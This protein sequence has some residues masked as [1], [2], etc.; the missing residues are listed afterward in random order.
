ML[1]YVIAALLIMHGLAHL[2]G[3]LG[4]LTSGEQAFEDLP[5]LFSSSITARSAVGKAWGLLWLAALVGFLGT[6]PGLLFGQ[7]WWPTLAVVAAA[8][9]L[10]AIVPW[11]RVVPPGA[12]AGAVLDLLII[13][14]LLP[15]WA[16]R[17]L[18]VLQ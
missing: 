12:W 15:P 16:D 18:Q 8:V 11:L 4:A 6:G 10:I 13:V 14:A 17:V 9:S 5:W 1:K 7:S 3:L 2:T